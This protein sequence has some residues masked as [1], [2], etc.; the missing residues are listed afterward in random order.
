MSEQ[1]QDR[2]EAMTLDRQ[3]LARLLGISCR[4]VSRLRSKGAIPPPVKIGGLVRWRTRDV[5]QFLDKLPA[6]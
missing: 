6:K 1:R 4:T 3:E 5:L 2:I